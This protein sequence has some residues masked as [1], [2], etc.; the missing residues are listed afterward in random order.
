M[1]DQAYN[2]VTK[3]NNYVTLLMIGPIFFSSETVCKK[4]PN[5]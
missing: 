5:L 3:G 1:E 4:V 2:F